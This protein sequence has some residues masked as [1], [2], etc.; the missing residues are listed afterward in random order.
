MS[1]SLVLVVLGGC[2]LAAGCDQT[3]IGEPKL[4]EKI[5]A[6]QAR[7]HQRY[8]ASQEVLRAITFGELAAAQ[9]AAGTIAELEE[10]SVLAQWK[11]YL[12]AVRTAATEIVDAPDISA[13]ARG[14]ATLGNS[15]ARC[16]D[17]AHA[18][19][20]L[21][22]PPAPRGD[23]KVAGE[24]AS[25]AW[26]TARMWDGLI[27]SAPAPWMEGAKT[28]EHAKLTI[29]AEGGPF[30]TGI[31]DDIARVRLYASRAQRATTRDERARVFGE[32]LQNCA[33]C[34]ATIRGP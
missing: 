10:P 24:M 33:G 25:H 12:A 18:R 1:R 32:L 30:A 28:L 3:A 6:A 17:A 26:S 8:A 31:S 19:I 34:H 16:H 27:A 22:S 9:K 14:L 13:A 5:K 23:G 29:V 7:M 2:A 15:C 4:A 20:V 11:P 21:R